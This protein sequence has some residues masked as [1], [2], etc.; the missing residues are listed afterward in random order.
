MADRC[1]QWHKGLGVWWGLVTTSGS[2]DK[3][4]L[5]T[6][7]P[8]PPPAAA[9]AVAAPAPAGGGNF[10]YGVPGPTWSN[11]NQAGQVM[12][13]T[14]SWASIG[15][16]S[17]LNGRSSNI[18]KEITIGGSMQGIID[19]AN[20]AGI[21]LL[22][23]VV[24]RRLGHAKQISS[25][26]RVARRQTRTPLPDFLGAMAGKYCGSSLKAIEVWNEQNLHYE[27]GN[28]P[29]DPAKYVE[30]LKPAYRI[31]KGRLPV[32]A[33]YQRCAYPGRQQRFTAKQGRHR[34]DG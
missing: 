10:G 9:P 20:N 4:A 12:Q 11:N 18:I 2:L 23:S 28:L 1:W 26:T 27:W 22:F 31:D 8:D 19:S 15:L 6:D 32:D 3:V 21:N 33:G 25:R 24:N 5:I 29:L 30:L 34:G 13:K 17:R 16:S 14:A 7:I